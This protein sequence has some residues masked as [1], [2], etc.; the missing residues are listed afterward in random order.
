VLVAIRLPC[1]PA[2]GKTSDDVPDFLLVSHSAIFGSIA[3]AI[4]MDSSDAY[5][6]GAESLNKPATAERLPT[7]YIAR[8]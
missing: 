7:V 5:K 2:V 1:H 3:R 8:L 6:T 4:K